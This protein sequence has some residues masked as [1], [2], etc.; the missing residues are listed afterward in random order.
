MRAHGWPNLLS[1]K[2]LDVPG[3]REREIEPTYGEV[4]PLAP[5]LDC[6]A[7]DREMQ[8]YI[9]MGALKV[10]KA[11]NE[12]AHGDRRFARENHGVSPRV[13]RSQAINRRCQLCKE[14]YKRQVEGLTRRCKS[15]APAGFLE[16]PKANVF[17][18]FS[19]PAA[20]GAVG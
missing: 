6:P 4:D 14:P 10:C 2:T 7:A 13:G 5:E 8:G 17:G 19:D 3:L 16:E 18:Q 11:W 20:Y 9:G 12:P 15:Q 1:K